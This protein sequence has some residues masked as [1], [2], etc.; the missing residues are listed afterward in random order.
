MIN[1]L[2]TYLI[3][4][5]RASPVMIIIGSTI[6]YILFQKSSDYIFQYIYYWLI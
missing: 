6:C 3:G 2:Q 1:K 5:L 4:F